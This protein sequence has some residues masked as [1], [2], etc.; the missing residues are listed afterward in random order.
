LRLCPGDF[1]GDQAVG[2]TDVLRTRVCLGLPATGSCAGA[3][4]DLDDLVTQAD[5]SALVL[6]AP[7]CAAPEP[8]PGDFDGDGAIDGS[9]LIDLR[10]CLGL[11]PEGSCSLGD[12]DGNGF[13]GYPDMA[14][15]LRYFGYSFCGP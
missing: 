2:G 13:V 8:C 10:R 9:D 7:T 3:D 12:L 4:L 15:A 6:G 1:D 5:F 14:I 11:L